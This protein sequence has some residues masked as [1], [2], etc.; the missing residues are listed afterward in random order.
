[1]RE[2]TLYQRDPDKN[3]AFVK[4]GK[5]I[6]WRSYSKLVRLPGGLYTMNQYQPQEDEA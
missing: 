2:V 6:T 4:V 1:V 3:Y 5:V